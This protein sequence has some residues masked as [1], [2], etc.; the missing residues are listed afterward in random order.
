MSNDIDEGDR[1]HI[2]TLMRD[3]KRS[4]SIYDPQI[5]ERIEG[6]RAEGRT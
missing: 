6:A 1:A 2:V 3:D 5:S 4:L